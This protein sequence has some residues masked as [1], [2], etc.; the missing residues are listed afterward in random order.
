MTRFVR[1]ALALLVVLALAG[2]G[3]LSSEGPVE[4]GREV[5]SGRP[6]DL[7]VTF[8]GPRTGE[9]QE[10]IVRGFVRAGAASDAAYDNARAFLTASVSEAWNPDASLVLLAEA[11]PPATVLVNPT[12]VRIT[13]KAAATVDEEGRHTAAPQG[14]TV[15]AE[16]Q[17]ETVGGQWRIAALPE[18]FGRWIASTEVNRLVRP[19]AVHYVSTSQR[20]LIPDVRWFP[21]DRLATRLARAQILPLPEHLDGAAVTAVP[22]GARLLGDAVSINSGVATVNLI[23]SKLAPGQTTRQNLWAQF[24]ATLIQDPAV[25]RVS[26][27]VDDVPVNLLTLDG[28]AGTLAEVGFTPPPPVTLAAPV[29]RRGE[30]VAVF[31]PSSLGDQEPREPADQRAYPAVPAG[32]SR[33]ALSADGSEVAAINPGGDGI[34]RWR[35]ANRYVVP[36]PGGAVGSPSYDRR[37]WLWV[38][39]VGAGGAGAPRLFVVNTASDPAG[40]DAAAVAIEAAWLAGRR[41]LEARVSPDG[42]RIAVLSTAADGRDARID[43][44]GIVRSRAGQPQRLASPLRL[45]ASL[46]RA[47]S[48]A[49]LDE[50]TLT[51]LGVL[52]G[53]T[54]QPVI[55]TVGGGVR[56][57]TAAP[58]AVA[59]TSTGGE[60]ALWVTTSTGRLLGRAGSQWVDS[61]PATDLAV[62][63]G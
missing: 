4:P 30:E 3:G 46:S 32:F 12:T 33:L 29:V 50:R 54:L 49:W 40:G 35:D 59:I 2:C 37:G 41:V 52:E 60:R 17:L 47:T 20:A 42:D 13:A 34:S 23:S 1:A 15:T 53:S 5:G 56:A 19:Y 39:A 31:D 16:F 43:L 28:S 18:G 10:S 55:V 8:N 25:T 22:S 7:R 45:G 51:A 57:L 26:L 61:G 48:L 36:L 21:V 24:V 38:G 6:A 27:S 9:S 58:D 11:A 63:S 44:T 62:A 14:S